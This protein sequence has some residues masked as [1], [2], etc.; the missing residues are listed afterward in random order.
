[1]YT[2]SCIHQGRFDKVI[3]IEGNY[4][5]NLFCFYILYYCFINIRFWFRIILIQGVMH[6]FLK[7]IH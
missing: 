6:L 4:L 5:L 1:M 3:I 2:H 7:I